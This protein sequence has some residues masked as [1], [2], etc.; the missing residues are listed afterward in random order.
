MII[1]DMHIAI[2]LELNKINSNL[3]DVI[4]PQEKDYFLNRAQER[5][6]KQRYGAKS[7][8]K[9]EG[10]EM[11]QK[12][13]DDLQNLLV[14]NYYDKAYRLPQSD[15]DYNTKVRFFLPNDY[16]FLTS[17]RSK[18]ALNECGTIVPKDNNET[19]QYY[20]LDLSQINDPELGFSS[21][22]IKRA[23]DDLIYISNLNYALEDRT[24]F[25][26]K[27]IK[28]WNELPNNPGYDIYLDRYRDVVSQGNLIF[29][30]RENPTALYWE[31]NETTTSMTLT[32]KTYTYYTAT[33]SED[34]VVPNVFAQQDDIYKMLTDPFNTTQMWGPLTIINNQFIDVF[35]NRENFVVKEVS[36]SYI[37]K[38]K[39]ISLELNQSCELAEETHAEIVRDAVN[40]MLENF[41]ADKRLSTSLQVEATN[42]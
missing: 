39:L 19:R 38:P 21:F 33:C 30:A 34:K 4:L 18:V 41:E 36:I 11:S 6:I 25:T 40:L 12:R 3:Y 10:F 35:I 31:Y 23:S 5:F 28:L 8:S 27:V 13:I 9:G 1:Q 29:V 42:E 2:D 17:Q 20:I 26:E 37:R 14:P 16:M 7:N 15:F 32:S 22:M 24:L